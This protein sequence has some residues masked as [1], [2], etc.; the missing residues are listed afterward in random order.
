[1]IK[2]FFTAIIC[3]TLKILN[4]LTPLG[5]L[6]ARLWIGWIFF[7]AGLLKV[8][9]WQSTVFLFTHEFSVP[10]IP[11]YLAAVVGT[12]AELILPVLLVL[13]LGGRITTLIFFIYN[14][15]AM[16]SYPHLWTPEGKAGLYQHINWGLILALL[17]FH[18]TGKLSLDY[19]IGKKFAGRWKC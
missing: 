15:I 11:S 5:D 6:A 17:M 18:G 10:L 13:G 4:F 3:Y 1:M 8:T 12:G 19:W 2:R 9:A 16:I 14:V 7:K